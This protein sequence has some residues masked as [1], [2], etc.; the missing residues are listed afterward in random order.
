[1]NEELGFLSRTELLG[2]K[3]MKLYHERGFRRY[4]MDRFEEYDLYVRNKDFLA[5]DSVLTFTDTNGRLMALKPD[6][7]LSLLKSVSPSDGSVSRLYYSE[8]VYRASGGDG[9]FREIPQTGV[10]FIGSITPGIQRELVTLA[11]ESLALCSADYAL[12]LS[13]TSLTS[14]FIDRLGISPGEREELVGYISRKSFHECRRLLGASG[15]DS[16]DA[17]RLIALASVS[18]RAEDVLPKIE[19]LCVTDEDRK[20]AEELR[21]VSEGLGN[22]FI[23]FSEI[24]DTSYYNGIIMRGFVYGSPG[25]VLSG[26]RYDPLLKRMGRLGGA[27]GFA[28]YMDSIGNSTVREK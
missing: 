7:T 22:V 17:E 2:M 20:E 9:G 8:S 6:V 28:V 10:E 23:D 24:A 13:H 19:S 16:E 12:S 1:M 4:R 3:L 15:A 18:G 27:I 5:T 25:R 14:S 11:C 26:G 21:F